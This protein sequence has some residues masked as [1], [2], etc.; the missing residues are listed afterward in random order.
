MNLT[1]KDFIYE[2]DFVLAYECEDCGHWEDWN[3]ES[4]EPEE[5]SKCGNEVVL[6]ETS[7][8]GTEC[9]ICHHEFDMWEDNFVNISDN[10]LEIT[11]ICED[12]YNDLNK[13]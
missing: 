8:E 6:N 13:K 5:Y 11:N 4:S 9:G 1:K 2:E 10:H 3:D 7:H 12:C